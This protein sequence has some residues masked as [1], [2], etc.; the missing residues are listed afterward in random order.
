MNRRILVA[1]DDEPTRRLLALC[2]RSWGYE[3]VEVPDGEQAW[4]VLAGEDAPKVAIVDW[5]MPGIDGAEVVRRVRERSPHGETFLLMLTARDSEADVAAALALGADDYLVK[6]FRRAELEMR[7]RAGLRGRH[8]GLE[9]SS[10]GLAT[11]TGPGD[12]VGGR[13]RVGEALAEGGMGRVHEG[14]HVELGN[15][16]AIKFMRPDVAREPTARARFAREARAISMIRSEHV[17]RV[18]DYGVTAHGEPYL[19]MER[20]RGETLAQAVVRRGPLPP[21]EVADLVAQVARGLVATHARGVLHRDI[22]PSN[23]FLEGPPEGEAP[24]GARYTAK[25]VDFGIAK[26]V[27]EPGGAPL[28]QDGDLLG[29]LEYMSP[30]RLRGGDAGVSGDLWSLGACAFFALTGSDAFDGR[31]PGEVVYRVCV[32]AQPRPSERRP[33]LPAAIDAWFARVC[34]VDAAARP[35]TA[36]ELAGALVEACRPSPGGPDEKKGAVAVP[37]GGRAW[38]SAGVGVV[39]AIAIALVTALVR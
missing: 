32:A 33:E 28:T 3:P 14:E 24:P 27:E 21:G 22:T 2:V 7:L 19:V 29:T 20:L 5:M 39:V 36:E 11:S 1:D 16:V 13:F 26:L 8:A 25:L 9:P 35:R 30:E 4:S 31:T 15:P 23:V 38:R 18:L 10:E 37:I 6:P 12:V 34:A 17:A